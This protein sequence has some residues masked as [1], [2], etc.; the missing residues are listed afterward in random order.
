MDTHLP[1][2]PSCTTQL[3]KRTGTTEDTFSLTGVQPLLSVPSDLLTGG[4]QRIELDSK[5]PQLTTTSLQC[6]YRL[7]G[8]GLATVVIL[9]LELY[10]KI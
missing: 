4:E 1:Q 7:I 10:S 8:G 6:L 2:V 9:R 5:S 3:E